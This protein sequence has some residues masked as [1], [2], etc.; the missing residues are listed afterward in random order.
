M[1]E[2]ELVARCLMLGFTF[3]SSSD[4]LY[5]L[6]YEGSEATFWVA[7]FR[8]RNRAKVAGL[9]PHIKDEVNLSYGTTHAATW[10]NIQELVNANIITGRITA[11]NSI[12]T[13]EKILKRK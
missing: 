5:G 6:D 9:Q 12:F 8:T 3:S 11:A 7:I 13:S 10:H 4:T 2:S 1:T